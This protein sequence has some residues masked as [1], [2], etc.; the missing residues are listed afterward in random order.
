MAYHEPISSGC[1]VA[2]KGKGVEEKERERERERERENRFECVSEQPV[3][4]TLL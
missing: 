2:V 3:E 4:R 1:L